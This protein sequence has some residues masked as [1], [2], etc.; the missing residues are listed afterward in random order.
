MNNRII[1]IGSFAFR[2]HI[3]IPAC[4]PA[5]PMTP[6]GFIDAVES[7]GLTRL[8]FCENL[9]YADEPTHSIRWMSELCREKGLTVEL[10]MY[11]LTQENLARHIRL[12]EVFSSRFIRVVVGELAEDNRQSAQTALEAIRALLPEL[13]RHHITLGIENHFDITT[14]QVIEIIQA[15]DDPHVG[16]VYDTTNAIGFI[17]HP[18]HTLALMLPYVKSVHLKDYRMNKVEAS[19]V[20]SGQILGEGVL[21]TENIIRQVARVNPDAS[22]I[23]EQTIRRLDGITPEQAVEMEQMQIERSIAY[24]KALSIKIV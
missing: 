10:G 7:L 15:I 23:M 12:A 1:G 4:T 6:F 3:G 8:Q 20:M 11:G 9:R 17:E 24:L 18:S 14:E 13:T 5:R 22:I 16:A 2:Y 21:D 19:I